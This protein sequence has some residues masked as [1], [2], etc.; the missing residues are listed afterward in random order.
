MPKT[1]YRFMKLLLIGG[2]VSF[3]LLMPFL[4]FDIHLIQGL[5]M[6]P[7]FRKDGYGAIRSYANTEEPQRGDMII[8]YAPPS[9]EKAGGLYAKRII[10][11]PGEKIQM[12]CG[13]I[14]I[15]NPANGKESILAEPYLSGPTTTPFG[16]FDASLK[17]NEFFV[18]ADNRLIGEDSRD[19]GSVERNA[20]V[21]KVVFVFPRSLSLFEKDEQVAI[22]T[23]KISRSCRRIK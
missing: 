12:R 13:E 21:G 14:Y 17:E 5:S 2:A 10:G 7:A 16:K 23:E 8:F 22:P 20:I 15:A 1:I 18:L 3:T 11:L 4:Y 9:A 19:F 6:A